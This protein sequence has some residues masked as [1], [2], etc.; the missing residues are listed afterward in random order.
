MIQV[1]G[2]NKFLGYFESEIEA[3]K[4][5]DKAARKYHREFAY[6]NFEDDNRQLTRRAKIRK[7]I[8]KIIHELTRIY[9]KF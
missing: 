1:E 2:K 9:T 4:A 6:Q 7:V 3:A 5:Y 8:I